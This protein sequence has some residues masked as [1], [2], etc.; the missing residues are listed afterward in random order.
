MKN[1]KNFDFLFQEEQNRRDQERPGI[2]FFQ[3][4]VGKKL[5]R[6]KQRTMERKTGDENG[7]LYFLGITI[8]AQ[9]FQLKAKNFLRFPRDLIIIRHKIIS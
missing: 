2:F 3:G 8:N 1:K 6:Q 7:K 5:V 9:L 4:K